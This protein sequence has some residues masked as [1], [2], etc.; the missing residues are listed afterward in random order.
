[1]STTQ[2]VLLVIIIVIGG[3]VYKNKQHQK[4]SAGINRIT[5]QEFLSEN[6]NKEGVFETS[7]G[8]QYEVLTQ[9]NGAHHPLATSKVKVHYH[10]TLLNGSV[11]DSSVERNS[12]ISFGLNQVISG[13]TEGVQLMKEGDKFRFFIPPNLG[14][15]DQ[16]AGKIEPGS[17]LI[18]EVELLKI[19]S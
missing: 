7:S 16:A 13:W 1:M 8:L 14:Y 12:P 10:G 2:I 11:F 17:L 6:V 19:E 18:F 3:L 5:A 9:G 4:E 15:G